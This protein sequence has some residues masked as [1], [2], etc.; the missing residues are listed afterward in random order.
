MKLYKLIQTHFDAVEAKDIPAILKYYH[1]DIDFIDPHYPKIHMKGKK[2]LIKGLTWGFKSVKTFK[3]STLNYFEN[4]DGTRASVEY[5]TKI[6]L[7]N[8]KKLNYPQVFVIE[9]KNGKICRLQAYETYGPHGVL[10]VILMITRF[11]NKLSSL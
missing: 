9:T 10:K 11:F 1:D 3:F 4:D 2:E 6:E 7:A 8:G 5:E